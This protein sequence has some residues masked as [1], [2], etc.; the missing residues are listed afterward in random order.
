MGKTGYRK[1]LPALV[2]LGAAAAV[3]SSIYLV[4]K[5]W[6]NMPNRAVD[7]LRHYAEGAFDSLNVDYV[8]KLK[9]EISH[10]RSASRP[11]F[12]IFL[13][14][15][16]LSIV[17]L[18]GCLG[19]SRD[20]SKASGY[21]PRL[22]KIWVY[23]ALVVFV[24]QFVIKVEATTAFDELFYLEQM[25]DNTNYLTVLSAFSRLHETVKS[26][27]TLNAWILIICLSTSVLLIFLAIAC[28]NRQAQQKQM[29]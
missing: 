10:I 29:L 27:D 21:L 22:V 4:D 5:I 11:L 19:K 13:L 3:F 14:V 24:P 2:L 18:H 17:I 15:C 1:F 20:I 12:A 7:D 28:W 23:T 8:K 26:I 9:P 25:S 16:I 6:I